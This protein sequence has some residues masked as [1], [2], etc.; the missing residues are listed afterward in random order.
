MY[1][2][3]VWSFFFFFS[4]CASFFLPRNSCRRTVM[5]ANYTIRQHPNSRFIECLLFRHTESKSNKSSRPIKKGRKKKTLLKGFKSFASLN[6]MLSNSRLILDIDS[7]SCSYFPY[8]GNEY[9]TRME[10]ILVYL[11]AR[12]IR[13]DFLV[14][15]PR[16]AV[17][18]VHG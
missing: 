15:I 4:M 11:F 8:K 2:N 13:L 18:F 17:Y 12:A 1:I 5:L 7:C 14:V 16:L 9:I 3:L 6:I 10:C